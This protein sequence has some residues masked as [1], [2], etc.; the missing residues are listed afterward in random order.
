MNIFRFLSRLGQRI[1]S[2]GKSGENAKT[3]FT[4]SKGNR[5][6]VQNHAISHEMKRSSIRNGSRG[7]GLGMGHRNK[8]TL[9]K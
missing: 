9:I 7:E 1:Y 3:W 4:D 8:K 6:K 2:G 5:E